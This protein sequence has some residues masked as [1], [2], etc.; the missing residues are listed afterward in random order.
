MTPNKGMELSGRGQSYLHP[1]DALVEGSAIV[2]AAAGS[3][4][5]TR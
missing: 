2:A 5:P 4:F 1:A 3:S